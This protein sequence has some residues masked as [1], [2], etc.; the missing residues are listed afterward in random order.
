MHPEQVYAGRAFRAGA[1]G[2]IEKTCST[3]QVIE[4]C[5]TVL[6]GK[7]YLSEVMKEKL[8][9]HSVEGN[10]YQVA[11]SVYD[12]LADRELETFDIDMRNSASACDRDFARVNVRPAAGP[13]VV[14]LR[15]GENLRLGQVRQA[16]SFAP[17]PS[18][19]LL[20]GVRKS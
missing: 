11:Q 6:S 12:R 19:L 1:D 14:C 3:D 2:Y 13:R 4:A 10:E 8:F 17:S 5:K 18:P 16:S 9:G 7:I 15:P 20:H